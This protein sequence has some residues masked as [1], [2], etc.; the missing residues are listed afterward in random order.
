[1]GRGGVMLTKDQLIQVKDYKIEKVDMTKE[2]GGEICIRSISLK[3]YLDLLDN[4]DDN[5]ML[6]VILLS[7]ANED[8]SLFFDDADEGRKILE[9][10]DPKAIEKLWHAVEKI[11]NLQAKA[12]DDLAK[13]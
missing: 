3:Q 1:M 12:V 8:G 9:A 2:W 11:N 7:C 5:F 6:S 13:N 10:K 4:K